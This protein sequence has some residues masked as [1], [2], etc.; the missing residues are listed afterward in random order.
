MYIV[1]QG[2]FAQNLPH[3]FTASRA[4]SRI[5]SPY[6]P[7]FTYSASLSCPSLDGGEPPLSALDSLPPF[8]GGEHFTEQPQR[9]SSEKIPSISRSR[10]GIVSVPA[11]TRHETP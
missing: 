4:S 8:G 6:Y 3:G 5:D 2:W 10:C 1:E 7:C 9:D 11:Y